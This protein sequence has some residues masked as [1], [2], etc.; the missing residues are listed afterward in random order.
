MLETLNGFLTEAVTQGADILKQLLP[1]AFWNWG[2]AHPFLLYPVVYL[3]VISP[4]YCVLMAFFGLITKDASAK[5]AAFYA[6]LTFHL[7]NLVMVIA[8]VIGQMAELP[9]TFGNWFG[10]IL[11]ALILDVLMTWPVYALRLFINTLPLINY[12][13][14]ILF[15]PLAL[16]Y[17]IPLKIR[18]LLGKPR[19]DYDGGCTEKYYGAYVLGYSSGATMQEDDYDVDPYEVDPE[20]EELPPDLDESDFIDGEFSEAEDDFIPTITFMRENGSETFYLR[21]VIRQ[22][23]LTGRGMDFAPKDAE[24]NGVPIELNLPDYVNTNDEQI[25]YIKKLVDEEMT[26]IEEALKKQ[27]K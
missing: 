22:S 10:A 19:Q 7:I 5:A 23:L 3:I 9:N 14:P 17:A 18:G 4:I 12:L 15:V 11:I 13:G 21:D 27:G 8:I 24:G 2:T 6:K 16:P 25:A 26:R 1:E 20:P